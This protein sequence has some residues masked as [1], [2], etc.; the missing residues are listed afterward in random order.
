MYDGTALDN[1]EQE[2]PRDRKIIE[3]E[4]EL[5]EIKHNPSLDLYEDA[6]RLDKAIRRVDKR[7]RKRGISDESFIKLANCLGYLITVKVP[8]VNEILQVQKIIKRK[9]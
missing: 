9:K 2:D 1:V 4:E 3:L 8:I 7:Q 5:R 6:R